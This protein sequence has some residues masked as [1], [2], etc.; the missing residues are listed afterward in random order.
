MSLSRERKELIGD[1]CV[2]DELFGDTFL[3]R[4]PYSAAIPQ[5]ELLTFGLTGFYDKK[6]LS[7]E[8]QNPIVIRSSIPAMAEMMEIGHKVSLV[9]AV[10]DAPIMYKLIR[11]H[12]A[13]WKTVIQEHGSMSSPPFRD[14][15]LL[16]SIAGM[17]FV[18]LPEV[19]PEARE[20]SSRNILTGI[21]LA[22]LFGVVEQPKATAMNEPYDTYTPY[23]V[24]QQYR[25][26]EYASTL[27]SRYAR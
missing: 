21:T 24:E 6:E 16:D 8:L 9:N 22:S 25:I 17:L 18:N 2:A 11:Q 20:G 4:V 13:N 15:I 7:R 14:L 27:R 26:E 23:F 10:E 1:R 12:L 3:V 19:T 5:E